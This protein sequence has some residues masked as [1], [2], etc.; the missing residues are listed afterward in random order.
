V[1]DL[2]VGTSTGGIL[3]LGLTVPEDGRPKHPAERLLGLYVSEGQAI[4]PGGGPQTFTQRVFGTRDRSAWFRDP[5]ELLLRRS[6]QREETR[7]ARYPLAGLES[8][9]EQYLG[10]APLAEAVG[11]VVVTSYDMAYHEPVMFSS[12]DRPG[13]VTD[14]SMRIAARATS[15]GPTYFEPQEISTEGRHRVLVDGGVYVN[16]PAVLGYLLGAQA[17]RAEGGTLVLVS[18]GTGTRPQQAPSTPD[19]LMTGD[20]TAV[21]R[22]LFAAMA[23][24]SGAMG[25]A[26]L[27]GVAADEA[28]RL[29]ADP[30]GRRRVQLHDGRLHRRERRVSRSSRPRS[31]PGTAGRPRG[32][33]GSDQPIAM[34]PE[35]DAVSPTCWAT[36][37]TGSSASFDASATSRSDCCS[38][39]LP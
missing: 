10:D 5:F 20:S 24:G 6:S 39:R 29:L 25:D 2:I 8:V 33:R 3:A 28:F 27:Q 9:L 30:D 21:A 36:S 14:F 11:D 32:N 18:L 35:L 16:N 17:A 1:F 38:S 31:R 23:S 12:R 13:F 7:G 37:G 19:E 4:F 22:A 34:P 26:L 15:A